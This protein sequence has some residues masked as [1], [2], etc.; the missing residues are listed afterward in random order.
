MSSFISGDERVLR[1]RKR[2]KETSSK[3]KTVRIPFSNQATRILSIPVIAD[4]YNYH[5]ENL[6]VGGTGRIGEWTFRAFIKHANSPRAF[7]IGRDRRVAETS[8]QLLRPLV[9]KRKLISLPLIVFC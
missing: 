2:P 3:A 8:S 7:V 9:Q 4:G 5:T 1:L 6:Q